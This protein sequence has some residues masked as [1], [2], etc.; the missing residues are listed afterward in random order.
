MEKYQ[1]KLRNIWKNFNPTEP[2]E[3]LDK[4]LREYHSSVMGLKGRVYGEMDRLNR[5]IKLF[6]DADY[7][8]EFI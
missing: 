1:R 2:D 3:E 4:F 5:A 7:R 6:K 8:K